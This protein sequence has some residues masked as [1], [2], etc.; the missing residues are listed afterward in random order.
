MDCYGRRRPLSLTSVWHQRFRCYQSGFE[1]YK[2]YQDYWYVFNPSVCTGGCKPL[3]T[4]SL[5]GSWLHAAAVI[6]P[7]RWS[8]LLLFSAGKRGFFLYTYC[9]TRWQKNRPEATPLS[10]FS[11]QTSDVKWAVSHAR[12]G[13][14]RRNGGGGG[15]DD[16]LQQHFP[17]SWI[18]HTS[19]FLTLNS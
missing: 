12:R 18:L 13:R 19:K 14:E 4:E 11:F 2:G 17:K 9:I 3:F 5:L 10:D 6:L 16:N 8:P 15:C 1:G 7:G